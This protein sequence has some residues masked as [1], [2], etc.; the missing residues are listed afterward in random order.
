[1]QNHFI[2][3]IFLLFLSCV[4]LYLFSKENQ[5]IPEADEVL[6]VRDQFP[7]YRVL[8]DHQKVIQEVQTQRAP[9]ESSKEESSQKPQ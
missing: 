8:Y 3:I 2:K 4:S 6:E 1:M 9:E 5:E 7:R